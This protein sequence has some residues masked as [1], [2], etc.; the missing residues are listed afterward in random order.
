MCF[1]NIAAAHFE[2]EHDV[3]QTPVQQHELTACLIW[4]LSHHKLLT[5]YSVKP[6]DLGKRQ[7][8]ICNLL[9]KQ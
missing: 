6:E 9:K 8:K 7:N 2:E 3:H 5:E 4:F 1:S